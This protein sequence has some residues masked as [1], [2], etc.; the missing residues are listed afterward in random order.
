M[1]RKN[2]IVG[3]AFAVALSGALLAM[4]QSTYGD[5]PVDARK[6][7]RQPLALL[8]SLPLMFGERFGLNA[9][10]SPV[11]GALS[12]RFDVKAIAVADAASLKPY[13]L[14]FMAHPRAQ[15]AEA[16]VD[17]DRWVRGGGRLVL[18]ADPR[19]DWESG[20]GLGDRLRPP[21]DF[22]DT[23]LLDHWGL[24]LEGPTADG[25]V[26]VDA[27]GLEVLAFSPGRLT[28]RDGQCS[29]SAGGF[30]ARCRVDAGQ[31]TVIAD[32]D[33]LNVSGAGALDGP[34]TRNLE[35]VTRELARLAR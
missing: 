18:L 8:T 5:A 29:T 7:E 17:L 31:V 35:L 15:P 27:D 19:L 21:P 9:G 3:A 6:V 20:R 25:P 1:T 26:S 34:T 28:A 23:G 4:S 11:V 2:W 33:F 32:A 12:G 13:G 22:A 30:I 10:S 14:L 24:T 16:L